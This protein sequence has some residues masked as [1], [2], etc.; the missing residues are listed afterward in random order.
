MLDLRSFRRNRFDRRWRAQNGLP[1]HL[2]KEHE[3]KERQPADEQ[4]E[5]DTDDDE[6]FDHGA[7]R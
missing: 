7:L 3:L 6:P 5:D 4:A 2:R 1:D